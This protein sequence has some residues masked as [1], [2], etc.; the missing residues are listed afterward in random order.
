MSHN[1]INLSESIPNQLK[2][3]I[4]LLNKSRQGS[5]E[6]KIENNKL[7]SADKREFSAFMQDFFLVE[8]SI[9]LIVQGEKVELIPFEVLLKL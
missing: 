6:L 1:G 9:S 5:L 4:G 2:M 8:K 3:H 7:V